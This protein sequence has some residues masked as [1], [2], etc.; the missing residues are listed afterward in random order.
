[1]DGKYV[2]PFPVEGSNVL[3]LQVLMIQKMTVNIA[4]ATET[5]VTFPQEFPN[6]CWTCFATNGQTGFSSQ[7]TVSCGAIS[8]SQCKV[9]QNNS[10]NASCQ[11]KI[12]AIGY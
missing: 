6:V 5:T 10:A 1:M 11:V 12:I 4:A 9:Y 2:P 3:S 8:K 7:D